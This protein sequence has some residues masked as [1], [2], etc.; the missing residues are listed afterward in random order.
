MPESKTYLPDLVLQ[1]LNLPKSQGQQ[2]RPSLIRPMNLPA[3]LPTSLG[4]G[5]K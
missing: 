2:Q 3:C 4:P 1:T 5:T